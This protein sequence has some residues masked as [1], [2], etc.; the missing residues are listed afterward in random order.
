[1]ST[2][3]LTAT[4]VREC[5]LET[6]AYVVADALKVNKPYKPRKLKTD[7]YHKMLR[8][9]RKKRPH[10]STR[11]AKQHRTR[12][13]WEHKHAGELK[14]RAKVVRDKRKQLNLD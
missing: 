9:A 6:L 12:E 14:R 1:M 2:L 3:K 4:F 10:D 8:E 11:E 13:K 5:L 7:P